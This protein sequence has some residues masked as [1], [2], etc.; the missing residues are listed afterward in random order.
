[1]GGGFS[2]LSSLLPNP[3]PSRPTSD[4]HIPDT[5]RT[6][7]ER[8]ALPLP[9]PS[10]VVL[11]GGHTTSNKIKVG[12]SKKHKASAS[13]PCR[14]RLASLTSPLHPSP[15]FKHSH[16]LQTD[17]DGAEKRSVELLERRECAAETGTLWLSDRCQFVFLFGLNVQA[18]FAGVGT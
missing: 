18:I 3:K 17:M 16:Q 10:A 8:R 1:M 4:T 11:S 13:R 2:L 15:V 7:V 9:L 12:K 5:Q 14:G 6:V